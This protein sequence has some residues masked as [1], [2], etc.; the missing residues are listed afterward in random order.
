MSKIKLTLGNGRAIMPSAANEKAVKNVLAK[1]LKLTTPEKCSG[2]LRCDGANARRRL[3][4]PMH[5]WEEFKI[6][7]FAPGKSASC[8]V[9]AAVWSIILSWGGWK[10][11]VTSLNG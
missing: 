10:S 6:G 2:H 5:R 3:K 1:R 11:P 7:C 4:F 9:K 8:E